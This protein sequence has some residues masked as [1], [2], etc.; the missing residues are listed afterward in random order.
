MAVLKIFFK[1]LDDIR[2]YCTQSRM[3]WSDLEICHSYEIN[4][5]IQ[6]PD[7]KCE[8]E[9]FAKFTFNSLKQTGLKQNENAVVAYTMKTAIADVIK[10]IL[11][12][13]AD[14]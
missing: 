9:T 11:Y 13:L 4:L 10:K 3:Q 7:T 14:H 2:P 5:N 1:I 8:M 12:W 6:K